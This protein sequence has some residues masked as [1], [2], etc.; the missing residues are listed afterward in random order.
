MP[1]KHKPTGNPPGRRPG[2]PFREYHGWIVKIIARFVGGD[3]STCRVGG[4][5]ELRDAQSAIALFH[6]ARRQYCKEQLDERLEDEAEVASD[7]IA[8]IDQ[9]PASGD[10]GLQFRARGLAMEQHTR[11]LQKYKTAEQQIAQRAMENFV[12]QQHAGPTWEEKLEQAIRGPRAAA[13]LSEEELAAHR[14]AMETM[15]ARDAAATAKLKQQHHD[16]DTINEIDDAL[17]QAPG[18]DRADSPATPKT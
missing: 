16:A 2:R 17:E 10:W 18:E 3:L 1:R 11:L 13:P 12:V 8:S 7:I 6:R 5:A 4:L 15:L 9:D 14:K